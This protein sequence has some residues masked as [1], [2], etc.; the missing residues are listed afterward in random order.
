ML[1]IKRRLSDQINVTTERVVDADGFPDFTGGWADIFYVAAE[2]EPFDLR[3]NVVVKFIAVGAEK[4]DSIIIVGIVRSGNDDS[5]IG[6]QTARDVSDAG[7]GQ[8]T[9]K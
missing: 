7:C 8:R 6:A 5:G 3:F 4:F 1:G 9:D 2:N